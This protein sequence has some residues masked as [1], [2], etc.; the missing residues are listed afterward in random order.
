MSGKELQPHELRVLDEQSE[1]CEKISKLADFLSK[2]QPS[3]IDDEQW[4]FFNLQ[5]NSMSMYSNILS[6]RIKAFFN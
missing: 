4:F 3:F 2:P 1:L 5:L 6:Q